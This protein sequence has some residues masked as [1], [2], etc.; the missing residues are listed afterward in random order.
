MCAPEITYKAPV[1]SK[2]LLILLW[3]FV[4]KHLTQRWCQHVFMVYYFSRNR[5]LVFF[6]ASSYLV[7]GFVFVLSSGGCCLTFLP[8]IELSCLLGSRTKR[9][10]VFRSNFVFETSC[11][12]FLANDIY[13]CHWISVSSSLALS[14]SCVVSCRQCQHLRANNNTLESLLTLHAIQ[15]QPLLR[16][17]LKLFNY[18]VNSIT[19]IKTRSLHQLITT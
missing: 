9:L 7:F 17:N 15:L 13:P 11:V 8:L 14:A 6:P 4:S 12:C 16:L 19:N 2:C 18:F 3:A 10:S 5:L 1:A